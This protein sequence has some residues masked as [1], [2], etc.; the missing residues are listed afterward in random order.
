MKVKDNIRLS[1][2]GFLSKSAAA[3]T[4]FNIVPRH[5]L[6]KPGEPSPN[7]KLNLGYI[8]AGGR[9]GAHFGPGRAHNIYAICDVDK[10]RFAGRLKNSPSAK[11]YQD[12]R[13]MLE[14]EKNLDAVF[15]AT[16]DHTHAIAA[17]SA[18]QLS[19][20]VYVEKPLTRT[21]YESR[22]MARA[23]ARYKV[24]TQMGNQGHAT[25]GARLTNEW[26]Q[27]GAIGDVRVAERNRD[28]VLLRNLRGLEQLGAGRDT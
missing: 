25:T 7:D 1:R 23:A 26:I 10:N 6:G 15:V 13:I 24:C 18:M 28:S 2:R 21:V 17:V 16:P 20:H 22:L 27:S 14:K 11:A 9:A 12:W 19:K 3:V 4:A 8:G 5:V